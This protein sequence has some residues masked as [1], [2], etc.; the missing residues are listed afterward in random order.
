MPLVALGVGFLVA[1]SASVLVDPLPGWLAVLIPIVLAAAW[2]AYL[3]DYLVRL[4][5]TPRGRRLHYVATHVV[6]LLSIFFP[7]FRALRLVVIAR[8][9]PYFRRRTGAAVRLEV[10]L[11][12]AA[13]AA[14]FVYFL[15]LAEL[16]A[17]RGAPGATITSFGEA[18]W[19]ACVTLATVGYGDTV[20]VTVWGR[21]I[22][23]MLMAG[24]VA[25]IGTAS[26][27]VFSFIN[28]Q[29]SARHRVPLQHG[30]D[31]EAD[32]PQDTPA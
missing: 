14:T 29:I 15:A 3:A 28:E 23:V 32:P 27:I 13:Y 6:E 17:E 31:G 18:V 22:A 26:A 5:L 16:Q 7:L 10:T 24:G 2:A 19:W 12:A 8:T 20:P 9:L 1:Y 30:D 4:A 25:I 11:F 21:V